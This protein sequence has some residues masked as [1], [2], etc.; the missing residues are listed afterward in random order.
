MKDEHGSY[1]SG[2]QALGKI[3]AKEH[4]FLVFKLS[5]SNNGCFYTKWDH[6][7][8][9]ALCWITE[10]GN[11]VVQWALESDTQEFEPA[12]KWSYVCAK[13]LSHVRL[14]ETLWTAACQ[15]P[16]SMEFSRQEYQSGLPF[17]SPREK[18]AVWKL[19]ESLPR[20]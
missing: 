4:S 20:N 3:K 7:H 14:F 18:A 19:G 17:P 6:N 9:R 15:P 2:R 10:E 16:L 11:T 13:S 8:L 5:N 1:S 12:I